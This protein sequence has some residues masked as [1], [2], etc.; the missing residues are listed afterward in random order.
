MTDDPYSS[1]RDSGDRLDRVLSL[2]AGIAAITAVAVSLYQAALAR[3]QL[4]ASAWPY[5]TQGNSLTKGSEYRRIVANQGVGP[6]R[7]RSFVVLVDGKPVKK[8]NDAVRGL[9]GD[10]E[11]AL[12]Y[13]S[14]G[15]GSVLPAGAEKALLVL[16][17]GDRAVKFWSEGQTRLRTVACFCSIYDECWSADSE[18]DEPTPVRSCPSDP[19]R[20]FAQ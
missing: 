8:W 14:F 13:S 17:W 20:E 3:Q 6:A 9:T 1:T 2:C 18:E 10:G 5:V 19:K 12:S 11:P 7:V 16:P 15:R 4:R